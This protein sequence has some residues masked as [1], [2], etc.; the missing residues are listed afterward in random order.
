[1]K[2][3]NVPAK[4]SLITDQWSPKIV[5]EVNGQHVKLSKFQGEFIWHSHDGDELFY[6]LD[7]EFEMHFEE[8][9]TLVKKGDLIVIPAG[10]PHKPVAEN[11]VTVLLVESSDTV[12]TGDAGGELTNPAEWI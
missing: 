10:V 1:M 5:S 3:I 12:N 9:V 4:C 7:G 8:G 2:P 6:V 11:E